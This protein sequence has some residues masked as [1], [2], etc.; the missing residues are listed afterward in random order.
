M[1]SYIVSYTVFQ[2]SFHVKR[3]LRSAG[4]VMTFSFYRERKKLLSL[5]VLMSLFGM[6]VYV[7]VCFYVFVL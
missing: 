3:I 1:N 7:L 6:F 4:N 2:N 5:W